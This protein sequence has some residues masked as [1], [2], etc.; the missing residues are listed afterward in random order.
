MPDKTF[1]LERT[2]IHFV[3]RQRARAE[4]A[5]ERSPR[6]N[7]EHEDGS[8]SE[9]E[10]NEKRSVARN[11]RLGHPNNNARQRKADHHMA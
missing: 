2:C 3:M 8:R 5:F 1:A 11:D 9:P 7:G 10:G 6:G 4:P